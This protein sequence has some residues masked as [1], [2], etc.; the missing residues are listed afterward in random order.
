MLNINKFHISLKLI[1]FIYLILIG[2]FFI[3]LPPP[4]SK[5]DESTHFYRSIS[6]SRGQLFCKENM[7]SGYFSIPSGLAKLTS[8]FNLPIY[9]EYSAKFPW[10]LIIS[11]NNPITEGA[12]VRFYEWCSLS[13]IPYI[14][15]AIGVFFSYPFN[16]AIV[17]FYFGRIS[18]F[19]FFLGIFWLSLRIAPKQFHNLLLFFV[20]I[21]MVLYQVTIYSYDVMHISLILL[22]FSLFTSAW[23]QEKVKFSQ[24]VIFCLSI[25]IFITTKPGYYLFLLLIFLYPQKR[26][27]IH[28]MKKST[29]TIGI[30][31][32]FLTYS[33]MLIRGYGQYSLASFINPSIQSNIIFSDIFRFIQVLIHTHI[34]YHTEYIRGFI[35]AFDFSGIYVYQGVY[36]IVASIGAIVI[37]ELL[38]DKRLEKEYVGFGYFRT[39]ILLGIL[40]GTYVLVFIAMYTIYSPM[41]YDRVIGVQGRYFHTLFLF[42]IFFI[43]AVRVMLRKEYFKYLCITLT[44]IVVIS[45]LVFTF[46][47]RYYNYS[48][49]FENDR[50]LET[51]LNKE[52]SLGYVE[53]H[54]EIESGIVLKMSVKKGEKIGA[55][56]MAAVPKSKSV[57]IPYVFRIKSADCSR[58]LRYDYFDQA[59]IQSRRILTQKFSPLKVTEDNLCVEIAPFSNKKSESQVSIIYLNKNPAVEL[60]YIR[61]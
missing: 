31:G 29:F 33:I 3:F 61:N 35:A 38:Q 17:A 49:T 28:V 15:N 47:S 30:V 13:F 1:I 52:V 25:L 5:S 14:P 16:N 54:K 37:Y 23:S 44:G 60:L 22:I 32:I 26:I 43:V 27:R 9:N 2:I 11:T 56:Q 20:S 4:F 53:N 51:R 12:D 57:T 10:K 55:I 59:E 21:P 46:Y 39:L 50:E 41:G 24:Y 8:T 18:G 40:I 19:I 36:L 48:E 6:V 7:V 34:L 42:F 58:L 45:L